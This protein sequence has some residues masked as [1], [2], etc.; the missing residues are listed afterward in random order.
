MDF[1]GHSFELL[2]NDLTQLP[3][4]R[5]AEPFRERSSL[6]EQTQFSEEFTRRIGTTEAS[7]LREGIREGTDVF[8]PVHLFSTTQHQ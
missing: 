4:G 3:S 6:C 5:A 8:L 7:P 1:A 2:G